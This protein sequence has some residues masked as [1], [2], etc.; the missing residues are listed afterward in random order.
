[1]AP[2]K[3][4]FSADGKGAVKAQ[5]IK[6]SLVIRAISVYLPLTRP[7]YIYATLKVNPLEGKLS[8][9]RTRSKVTTVIFTKKKS[10]RLNLHTCVIYI[11]QPWLTS[12]KSEFKYF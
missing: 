4:Y 11:P 3:E 8:F 12:E 5:N 7:I 10:M 6:A 2:Y 9:H 1:M